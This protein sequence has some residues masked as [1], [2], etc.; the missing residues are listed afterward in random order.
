MS[1]GHSR[2]SVAS[3]ERLRQEAKL[4]AEEER[5]RAAAAAAETAARAS[6][7]AAAEL[8]AARAEAAAA[9]AADAARA[10]VA[11]LEALRGGSVGGSVADGNID[12]ELR[13]LEAVQEQERAARWAAVHP[14]GRGGGSP[15]R[16][17]RASDIPGGDARGGRALGGGWTVV[18]EVGPGGG[19]PTLT[20]TNYVVWAAV[21]RV[22][23]QVRHMWDAVRYG[24]VDYNDDQR[25]LDAL[26]AAVPPEMQFTLSKKRTAKEAWDAITAARIGSDRAR[27]ST[28]QAFRKEWENLA[29]K[30]GEDVDDFALRVNTLPQKMVQFG[31]NTYDEER[32]VEKL[33][34]CIP[35]RYKQIARSIESMLDLSTMSIEEAIGRLKVVDNNEPRPHSGPITIGGKLHLTREQWEAGLGDEKK[36]GSSTST[37]GRKRDKPRKARGRAQGGNAQGGAHGKRKPARYDIC[38]NCGNTGHWAR[39][40]AS[41]AAAL[42]HLDESKASA[43]L[44]NG[45]NDDKCDGWCLDTSATHHMTRRREYFTELDS[46]VQ[47]SV[48]FGDASGVEIK[49]V[50]SVLFTAKSGEHRLLTE[51]YYI[52]ALRNSIIS[53]GQLDE[54]GSRVEIDDGL[55]RVWDTHGRLLAKV[56]RGSN[57]LYILHVKVAQP[58]CLAAR[59]D[60]NAWRWHE[61]FG[62]L[63]FEALKQLGVKEMGEAV[64]TAVYILNCSSTKA[65]DGKMSYEA[66]HGRKPTVSHL[67]TFGCLAFAKELG[68]IG[69][70]DDRSTPGVFIGYAEGLKVYRILDPKTQHV[71]TARDVVFDEGR[72][73]AWDKAVDD[74]STPTYDFTV[75]YVHFERARG[76]GGSPSPSIPEP[77]PT[78]APTTPTM[79]PVAI[80]SLSTL[81]QPT[82]P[83]TP[84]PTPTPP[85]TSTPTPAHVEQSPVEFATPLS[86]DE[87]RIDA[88]HDGEPLRYRTMEDILGDQP[89]SGPALRDLEAQLHLACDDDEPR[90]FAEAKRDGTWR[91]AMQ[92]K[93]DAVAENRTWELADL[94]RGQ[95]AI[96]LKWVFKL[97]RDEAGAIVK[98][99]ARLV[100]RGFVQQEGIDF[101]DAFAPVARMESVRL[102]LALAAQE[103]WCVHHMD[104]KSAFLNG[105]LKEEAPRVWNAKLDSTLKGMGFEQ[106]PHEAAIYRR[107]NGGNALLVGVYV[108]DLVING[109]K[110]AE[111]AAFKE[112]M[113][114]TFQMSDL[115]PLS[116]YLGIEVHH[117]DSRITLRQTA[118]AKRIVE[119]AGLTDCNPTLT[120]MEERLKLRRHNTAQE[121]DATQYRRLVGSLRYLAHT[122]PDLAFSIGTLDHGLYYPRCPREAHFIG[123]SDS[124][125]AG[126]IDTSKSTSRILFFLGKCLVS[127]QSVKQPVVAMSSCEA[128]YVAPT[129][130]STQA[131]WLAR[132]LG[133][134]LGRDTEAVELQVDSTSALALAK[135]PVFHERSKH[136]RVR[137]HFIRGCLE[138]GSIK[139]SYINTNDQ[140]ADLLTKPLGRVK[141]L[142]LCPRIGMV[143]PP[144]KT[145]HKT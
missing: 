117:D 60:D 27:R 76:A 38:H 139:A 77:P 46:S 95:R 123:Y 80:S 142:E 133:D 7:L 5:E 21:M 132:L 78:P 25:A 141:F 30:P 108:D 24:D 1:A 42:L 89:V 98:H 61:H 64:V 70:L 121:V 109:T 74:G 100:A 58:L 94:P 62:H 66:W 51:V 111:V 87:E 13:E 33:L 34:R 65:L 48:K 85:G 113:K 44:G 84:A 107:G 114:A 140:L 29:F 19:W 120:P 82:S 130:A 47:G 96:T 143:Q 36:G 124:D 91:A 115:G 72:G 57:H 119:L 112:D 59:R 83:S 63:N 15:D 128:E 125:H 50:G 75:E 135:N 122:R 26:I 93:K 28:L 53:L 55:L 18:R 22:R 17:G 23:L 71:R 102:L 127:W 103:G 52:P 32:A 129:T 73:W 144:H 67:R 9:A 54:N 20:K 8:A 35:K 49:G 110:D 92:S 97:K 99:K 2:R 43:F 68:H 134:L 86:R 88:Y 31:D 104:V 37:G 131:L 118:Y 4:A 90:S 101:D 41:P 105:D 69:K 12:E 137:Y 136:I 6:R 11:D 138:E 39:D 10:A 40:S 145:T 14:H 79:T 16:R 56:R 45:S 126:D 116:F 3:S 106:S 81:P